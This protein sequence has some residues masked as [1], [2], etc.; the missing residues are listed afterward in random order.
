V[1]EYRVP[2][3]MDTVAQLPSAEI[4]VP[5]IPSLKAKKLRKLSQEKVLLEL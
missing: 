4:C 5:H 1:D 3:V 2:A